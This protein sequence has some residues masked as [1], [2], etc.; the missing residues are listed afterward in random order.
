LLG[1]LVGEISTT[2]FG[3]SWILLG[4]AVLTSADQPM[5]APQPSMAA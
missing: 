4:F 1:P 5:V 3:L 2:F